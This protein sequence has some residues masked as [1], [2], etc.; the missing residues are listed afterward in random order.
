MLNIKVPL[1]ILMARLT[2]FKINDSQTYSYSSVPALEMY[3]HAFSSILLLSIGILITRFL[4][5]F[6]GYGS[7][8]AG[9]R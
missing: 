8:P 5:E 9:G 4:I 7:E 1:F 6:R 3:L 2:A